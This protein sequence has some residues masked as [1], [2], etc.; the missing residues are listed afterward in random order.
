M[1]RV[2]IPAI[3]RFAPDLIMISNGVD[4]NGTDPLGRMMCHS[5]TFR[6]MAD[7]VVAA[8]ERNCGGKLVA[9]HEGGYSAQIA[10]WCVL[11]VIEAI[12]GR[13]ARDLEGMS[14]WVAA[15]GGQEIKPTEEAVIGA[16]EKRVSDV[17]QGHRV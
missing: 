3:D 7:A 8:A 16:A 5:G 2:V 11:N 12:A 13:P 6:T 17:P 14:L 4:A 1:E 9:C 15:N 10:P